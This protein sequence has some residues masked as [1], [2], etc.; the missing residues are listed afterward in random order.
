MPKTEAEILQLLK[1]HADTKKLS[2]SA[3][4]MQKRAA[5]LAAIESDEFQD[6]ILQSELSFMETIHDNIRHERA[7]QKREDEDDFKKRAS[8]NPVEPKEEPEALPNQAIDELRKEIETLKN[9]KAAEQK[10]REVYK[11][12]Y[13]LGV[14]KEDKDII[15]AILSGQVI[16]HDSDSETTSKGVV[17]LY[18][19]L[20]TLSVS[21]RAPESAGGVS[22][23]EDFKNLLEQA[24]N[25]I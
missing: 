15:D 24:K 9:A 20:K 12:I 25:Y 7:T 18:N 5:T 16:T 8:S 4:T 2:V 11:K 3:I 6:S 17:E 14:P 19:K 1:N 23:D 13:E 22:T 21:N 10:Q